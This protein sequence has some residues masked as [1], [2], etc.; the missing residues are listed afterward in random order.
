MRWLARSFASAI[1][2]RLA[3]VLVA[4]V[5]ASCMAVAPFSARAHTV[6]QCQLG[7]SPACEEGVAYAALQGMPQAHCAAR[8]AGETAA[9]VVI[10]HNG[11]NRYTA[12]FSCRAANGTFPATNQQHFVIYGAKC[13]A[14]SSN[15][16]QFMPLS[17]STR[18]SNG[19]IMTYRQN[20]DDETST[21]SPTGA[22]CGDDFPK[23]C[24]VGSFW[25]GYMN[26]CQPVEPN[27][28]EGQEKV[29]G[30]CKPENKCPEGMVA[31]Q[32]STPGAVAQGALH[33]AP[34]AE[35][36][37]PGNIMSPGGKC[38]PG[39][40]Q[41][42]KGETRGPDGTCKKDHNEDGQP[43]E[44]GEGEKDSASGGDDCNNPPSCSGNAIQC[45]Q[46]KIQWRID[47]NTRR[48][49]NIAGGACTA[50][51]VCTG[52][53]CDQMQYAQL[54][55]QWR[56][57]CALEKLAK[58][59]PSTPGTDP[60]D[61][62]K[63]GVADVLEGTGTVN[64]PGDGAADVAGAKKFGIGLSTNLLNRENFIGTGSCPQPPTFS[65]MGTTISGAE[66]PQFCQLAVI[67]RGLIL[68]FGAYIAVKI[69]M[70]W[71]F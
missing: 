34:K 4:A 42:A 53:G 38:L 46:V 55:Q 31:V 16:T 33:C 11:T 17:G 12:T 23:E 36:C 70:G 24:P 69:L 1:I 54:M 28:P 14:R 9:N 49:V 7:T 30:Q 15:V 47:C 61:A 19:C 21:A 37:P 20:G 2:R 18:C 40:N 44:P 67:L 26:V 39:E 35:E 57:T 58:A 68:L 25:N 71:G 52:E 50:V 43:D 6:T 13:S 3:Y 64:D 48:K 32:A 27:C 22:T 62:N 8:N 5:V 63:N 59:G 41:C 51:P 65:I 29:N 66:F 10:N 56:S 60:A 45:L